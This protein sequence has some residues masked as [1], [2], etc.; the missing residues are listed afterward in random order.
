MSIPRENIMSLGR[1]AQ[2][3]VGYGAETKGKA[4]G[5]KKLATVFGV[6]AIIAGV[7]SLVDTEMGHYID[8]TLGTDSFEK[9]T[10]NAEWTNW[11][12]AHIPNEAPYP[13]FASFL[14]IIMT[15]VR[16]APL[17]RLAIMFA[18]GAAFGFTVYGGGWLMQRDYKKKTGE[19]E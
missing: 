14:N 7:E 15:E 13:H 16:G 8:D 19:D 2:G 3:A 11:I 6:A 10:T 9:A 17:S 4:M 5:I 12:Y 1:A 18:G